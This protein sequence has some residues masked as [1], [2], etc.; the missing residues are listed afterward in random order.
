MIADGK[1]FDGTAPSVY[2]KKNPKD[3]AAV[4]DIQIK[5]EAFLS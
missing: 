5:Q 4:D 2:K 3:K 1:E